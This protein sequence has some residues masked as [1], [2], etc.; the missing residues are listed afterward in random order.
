V[1]IGRGRFKRG[2][3]KKILL[4]MDRK[5][6]GTTLPARGLYLVKVNY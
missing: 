2:A 5:L 4:V 3:L 1:D 6:I